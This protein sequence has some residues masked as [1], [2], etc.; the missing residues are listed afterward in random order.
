MKGAAKMVPALI[1]FT[2]ALLVGVGLL[3]A[4]RYGAIA[5]YIGFAWLIPLASFVWLKW[6][7]GE[8]GF[9]T[10]SFNLPFV[11]GVIG[12]SALLLICF[13]LLVGINRDNLSA[14][15]VVGLII[16]ALLHG[17]AF[18]FYM[19]VYVSVLIFGK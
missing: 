2:F 8:L 1:T 18:L 5:A 10:S 11:L 17:F 16:S 13:P 4:R 3:T 19:L 9:G 14:L 7:E 12:I 6:G 15:T